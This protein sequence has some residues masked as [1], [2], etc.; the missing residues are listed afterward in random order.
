[1]ESSK[2]QPLFSGKSLAILLSTLTVSLALILIPLLSQGRKAPAG[3]LRI[4]VNG[5]FYADEPLGRER[6]VEI[7][8]QDGRRNVVHITENG[9]FMKDSTCKNHDCVQQGEVTTEN[10]HRRALQNRVLCLPNGVSL[11]LVLLDRTPV[12]DLPDF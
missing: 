10:Y 4:T 7:L 1:M 3:I 11:E 6:D 9:F 5:Q 8:Q 12:P 2:K